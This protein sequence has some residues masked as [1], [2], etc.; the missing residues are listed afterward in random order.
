MAL[1]GSSV[2]ISRA[3]VGAPLLT[4][5]AI[6]YILASAV[7]LILARALGVRLTRPR[8]REWFWL[9]SIS[10]TGLALFNVAIVRGVAQ[11]GPAMIAVAVACVP[12]LLSVLGPLLQGQA[13]RRQVVL[14]AVIVT[15]GAVLVEGAGGISAAGLAWAGVALACEASFTLLAI[16]VLGRHGAWGVSVHSIWIGSVMLTLLAL[17]TEGPGA[18][19]RLTASDFAAMGYL[20]VLVTVVAFLLW[21]S[22]VRALGPARAGVLTGIAPVSAALTGMATGSRAPSLA[23]WAGIAVVMAGLAAG[24][25]SRARPVPPRAPGRPADGGGHVAAL[26]QGSTVLGTA[27]PCLDSGAMQSPGA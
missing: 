16:P 11:A 19:A 21:Y 18:A 1:V 7:L 26:T 17:I 24:L 3:L 15:A 2:G 13:P 23:M 12:V 25:W 9:A 22:T 10:A 5:Q 6:R 8:G 20:A 27:S 14:A 4:A